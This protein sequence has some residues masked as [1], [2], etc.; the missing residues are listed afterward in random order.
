RELAAQWR[1]QSQSDKEV[2]ERAMRHFREQ[3]FSYTLLAEPLGADPVDEFLFET[4]E[5]YCE[6][7]SSSFT[8]AMRAAGIPARV[9]AG[10]Q[11]GEFNPVGK[12]MIVPQANAHAWSEVW[13]EGEGWMRMDPTSAVAPDR[14]NQGVNS[15]LGSQIDLPSI[16]RRGDDGLARQ[17]SFLWD[18]VNNGWNQFVLGYGIRHQY[19]LM[20]W[21]GIKDAR[22]SDLVKILVVAMIL[23]LGIIAAWMFLRRPKPPHPALA[24]YLR[25]RRR[26][27]RHG[28][29]M[30]ASEAPLAFRDRA[31]RE[32]PEQ[33][34]WIERV[35]DL[36]VRAY[37]RGDADQET[38]KA[39]KEAVRAKA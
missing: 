16:A 8:F 23:A 14:V 21:L 11:G 34:A 15:A 20:E 22:R 7:F 25:F 4:R 27:A 39:L 32:M 12:Y 38:L 5:G 19:E 26:L 24:A 29:N 31:M 17:L 28:L 33:S 9:V 2:V 3:P 10:Y 35:T 13:L 30:E 37:Y 18:A 1:A 36:F 6:H